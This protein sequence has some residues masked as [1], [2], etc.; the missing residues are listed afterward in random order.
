MLYAAALKSVAP[1]KLT[2]ASVVCRFCSLK[3]LANQGF[4]VTGAVSAAID[5]D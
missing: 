4:G 1:Q 5:T 2:F 3:Q